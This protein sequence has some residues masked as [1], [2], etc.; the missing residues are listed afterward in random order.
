MLVKSM[1]KFFLII[2]ITILVLSSLPLFAI[3][4][5]VKADTTPIFTGNFETGNFN[6]WSGPSVVRSGVT[7]SVQDTT[8]FS[9]LYAMKVAVLDGSGESGTFVY[10]DLG[11]AY[12]TINARMYVELSAKPANGSTIEVFGFSNSGWLPNAVGTRVDIVNRNGTLQWRLNY[13]NGSWQSDYVG[14]IGLNTWY[15]VETKLVIGSGSGE[16][17]LYVDDVELSSKTNLTNTGPGSSV[18]FFS[19]G[20]DDETGE[21]NFNAYFDSVVVAGSYIGPEIGPNPTPTPTPIGYTNCDTYAYTISNADSDTHTYGNSDT[22]SF[23]Y[24]NSYSHSNTNS[25]SNANTHH[26]AHTNP[27]PN[28]TDVNFQ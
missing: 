2:T 6:G 7:A 28:T 4:L 27:K 8:V 25:Y 17:H 10:K 1:K 11:S 23:A 22:I 18:R 14:Q 16:T 12:T 21:N 15:C 26:N 19:V 20:I 5:Y 24:P 9:G 13:Y 3:Q